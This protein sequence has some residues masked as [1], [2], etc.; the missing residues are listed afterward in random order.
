M[1]STCL[2]GACAS[3]GVPSDQPKVVVAMMIAARLSH[4]RRDC[5][6]GLLGEVIVASSGC[7]LKRH[8]GPAQVR[9][10]GVEVAQ[11]RGDKTRRNDKDERRPRER[12]KAVGFRA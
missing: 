12:R 2:A 4:W 7:V 3:A 9:R 5:A 10:R 6:E 1:R 11:G 8:P